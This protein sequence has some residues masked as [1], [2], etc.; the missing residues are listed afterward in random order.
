MLINEGLDSRIF[1]GDDAKDMR[2]MKLY[3]ELGYTFVEHYVVSRQF[4]MYI[5]SGHEEKL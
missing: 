4:P 5:V 2:D 1:Y 3:K